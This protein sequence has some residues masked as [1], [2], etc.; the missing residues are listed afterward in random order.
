MLWAAGDHRSAAL[1]GRFL[2]LNVLTNTRSKAIVEDAVLDAETIADLE[3]EAARLDIETAG[4]V[5]LAEL[6]EILATPD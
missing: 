1:V 6:D 2:R 4:A 5:V 3:A